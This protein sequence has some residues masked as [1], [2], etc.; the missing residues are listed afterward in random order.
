MLAGIVRT[1]R[2]NRALLNSVRAFGDV[3]NKFENM[4]EADRLQY[5]PFCTFK[6]NLGHVLIILFVCLLCLSR[7]YTILIDSILLFLKLRTAYP[8]GQKNISITFTT[9]TAPIQKWVV[10]DAEEGEMLL[11]VARRHD[12]P[13]NASCTGS[14]TQEFDCGIGPCCT[15]CLC[16]ISKPHLYAVPA[17]EYTE[18]RIMTSRVF[19]PTNDYRL[20]CCVEV[21]PE[22]DGALVGF[23]PNA[24]VEEEESHIIHAA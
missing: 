20:S 13:I 21:T 1:A 7:M 23:D 3:P 6:F 14:D 11:N 4:S 19:K 5:T 9:T 17:P 22:F 18:S 24:G 8:D 15:S 12:I 16:R 2:V 10:T